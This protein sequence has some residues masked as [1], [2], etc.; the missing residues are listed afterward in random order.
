MTAVRLVALLALLLAAVLAGCGGDDEDVLADGRYF[1]YIRA[2]E[3]DADRAKISLD[4]AAWLT[5]EQAE[6]AAREDGAIAPGEPV[7]NDYY[8]RN[9]QRDVAVLE[10]ADRV[11]VTAVR[12]PDSCRDGVRGDFAGLAR[13][14]DD[15]GPKTLAD[16][17]RGPQS[18]YWVTVQDGVV[19]AIDEQYV[20]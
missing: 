17:Y 15:P 16:D 7:S 9:A 13:S 6:K 19:T 4:V 5:G 2:L 8:V 14:F 11:R 12:C 1:G 3:A 10:V 20:P 18:Q